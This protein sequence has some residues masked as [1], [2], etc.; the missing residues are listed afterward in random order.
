MRGKKEG[1]GDCLGQTLG[2]G[3]WLSG[4]RHL[5][6][7]TVSTRTSSRLLKPFRLRLFMSFS[8][9]RLSTCDG[10]QSMVSSGLVKGCGASTG[11]ATLPATAA[12]PGTEGMTLPC[13][14]TK[15]L[16]SVQ[17]QRR[18]P[19]SVSGARGSVRREWEYRFPKH[20]KTS[21][22]TKNPCDMG[23]DCLLVSD[24]GLRAITARPADA[25]LRISPPVKRCHW[26]P[27]QARILRTQ[28]SC[29]GI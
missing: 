28:I 5:C 20:A 22:S 17:A 11:D 26:L 13:T 14:V 15:A 12:S 29:P 24:L 2:C 16:S 10:Q 4:N 21:Q 7:P 19:P 9:V 6:E 25:A 8:S 18:E 23:R 3:H 1:Q 27:S